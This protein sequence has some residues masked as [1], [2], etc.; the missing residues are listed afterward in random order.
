M[1]FG[2]EWAN[3][4]AQYSRF[5]FK[6]KINS[7]V[8][9]D[10]IGNIMKMQSSDTKPY[11]AK[12]SWLDIPKILAL[13]A[14]CKIARI[15]CTGF[16]QAWV[17]EKIYFILMRSLKAIPIGILKRIIYF[18]IYFSIPN[19]FRKLSQSG[20]SSSDT[21][22]SSATLCSKI[23]NFVFLNFISL[24]ITKSYMQYTKSIIIYIIFNYYNL[25]LTMWKV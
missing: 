6:L 24:N 17:L 4:F 13:V 12:K 14:F 3:K 9:I 22:Y 11:Y 2:Y 20:L 21:Y 10:F 1:Y 18:L 19:I 8:F 25:F 16:Y 15:Y 5:F 7:E 23:L